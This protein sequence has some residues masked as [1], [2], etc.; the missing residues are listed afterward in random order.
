MTDANMVDAEK[1]ALAI[2][3]TICATSAD[4][5]FAF[6]TAEQMHREVAAWQASNPGLHQLR[7]AAPEVLNAFLS[8]SVE[9]LRAEGREHSN[10]RATS[11]LADAVRLALESAPK[12]LPAEIVRK[13]FTELREHVVV[14]MYFPFYQFLTV[15]TRDQVTDEIRVE[16][17]RL[18][19]HYA[20]SP[21][22]K[23]EER[24][25][26]MRNRLAE[27][28]YVEGEKQLDPGRG[29]W[30]QI[31]FD[32]IAAKDD[33]TASAWRGLLEHCFQ[34][35]Q[36]VPGSKWKK[37]AR[38][39]V[40][41][42]GEREVW[43][44]TQVWLALGP[45]PGQPAEARSP[46]EDSPYQKGMVWVLALSN[47]PEGAAAIGD[48]ALGCLR[49]IRMLGAVSQKVGFACV[50][51]LGSMECNE[52]ISQL[53]RLRAK[54]KY[55]VAQRLIEKC[56]QQAAK[57]S[58]LTVDELEDFAVPSYAMDAEGK[59]E[60]VVGDATAVIRV[61]Q[62]AG[63]GKAGVIWLDADG[64]PVKSV[65]SHVKKAFAKEVKSVSALAKDLERDYSAQVHRLESSLI[66]VRTM[67]PA[68]W[69]KYFIEHPLLGLLGRKLIWVFS[70]EQGWEASGLYDGGQVRGP[71]GN[72]TDV[73]SA[74]KVRL[75]HPLSSQAS[76]VLRWRERVFAASVKQPFR[77]AFRESYE[78]TE[79]ER[80]TKTYSNRFAG[81]VMRQHQ[82]SSLCRA[83]GWT[84]RLMGT[85]FDGFNVPTKLLA[86]WNMHAE[87]YVDLPPDRDPKLSQSALGEQSDF[88]INL[89]L[90]SDQ[91]RFYRDRKEVAIEDVPSI[92]YS[93]VMR[94]VDLF[95]SVGA[96]GRDE[97][98]SDQGDRGTGVLTSVSN[99]G[100]LSAVMALRV[101]MLSRVL[102]LTPMVAQCR[103]EKGWVEVRG[104]LG[105]YLINVPW[106]GAVRVTDSGFRHLAIP[107]KLLDNAPLNFSAFPIDLDHRTETILRKAYILA[108]DW[109]IDSPDLIRQ[110][111]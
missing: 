32:E 79:D 57:R 110:L 88:D 39:L 9:W 4:R 65:P 106:G 78:V 50:Q 11:T 3:E 70:D 60:I 56:L 45:T 22:G 68:H 2:Y 100:E 111:M 47:R 63:D 27:L 30:S 98:W 105:T 29:P 15:V 25:L 37:R 52:A 103:I 89:F 35:E 72:A 40:Q 54:V 73:S 96:V 67:P 85:D 42:L 55:A 17:R 108:N 86:S 20:P 99:L 16:L 101:E 87:F 10:F 90:S 7:Q 83:K 21:T 53:A 8:H 61:P 36:T 51:A 34:L 102:P 13:L 28:I 104:Q 38:D 81:V 69:Q 93:E 77:Q 41:A 46:I 109:K 59:V 26:R 31:V 82:F 91:V 1:Q 94:E 74:T 71:E 24:S 58:G 43:E 14:R 23:V 18:H 62:L 49:K 107:Q 95:T 66:R 97:S 76:E 6:Q 33:I 44:A 64:K 80:Q 75:W 84:Y 48:F 12:P 92:V 5:P 19:L